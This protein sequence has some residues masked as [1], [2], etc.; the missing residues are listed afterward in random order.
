MS[1]GFA[2]ILAD[3]KCKLNLQPVVS[4]LEVSLSLL[5]GVKCME[6]SPS[7][8][9]YLKKFIHHVLTNIQY[10]AKWVLF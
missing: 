6:V 4:D 5:K 9:N 10:R 2:R 1:I 8:N 7:L 3:L